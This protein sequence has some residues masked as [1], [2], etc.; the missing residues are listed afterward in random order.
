MLRNQQKDDSDIGINSTRLEITYFRQ[1]Q[2]HKVWNIMNEEGDI[3]VE[4]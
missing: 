3:S 1:F 2:G 4:Q